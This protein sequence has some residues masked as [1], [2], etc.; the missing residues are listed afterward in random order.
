MSLC[1]TDSWYQMVTRCG[2]MAGV[3]VRLCITDRTGPSAWTWILT[4]ESGATLAEQRVQLDP[5]DP[6]LAIA[7]DLYRNLWRTESGSQH[8]F[9]TRMGA[10]IADRI[11]GDVGR[12]LAA[13]A[14]VTARVEVPESAMWLLQLPLELA[15][16]DGVTF[17]Y[18]SRPGS[19]GTTVSAVNARGS[20]PSSRCP[21]NRR[22]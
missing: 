19:Y 12:A 7:T 16:L 20:W 1:V 10:F 3:T 18:S 13:C 9:L 6:S 8:R 17:C 11:L 5:D 4:D 2:N 21:A 22:L 15:A 14:P